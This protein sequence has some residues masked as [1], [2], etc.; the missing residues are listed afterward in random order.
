MTNK[1]CIH[2]MREFECSLCRGYKLDASPDVSDELRF[3]IFFAKSL[4]LSPMP[5][6]FTLDPNENLLPYVDAVKLLLD[7]KDIENLTLDEENMQGTALQTL[8][9]ICDF[10]DA[11][12][13][14]NHM[15]EASNGIE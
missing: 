7:L 12:L 5:K 4:G 13:L 9:Q 15:E 10:T 1:K 2:G 11:E 6:H 3:R 8:Q 14:G